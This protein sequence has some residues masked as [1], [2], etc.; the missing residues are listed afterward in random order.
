MWERI[1]Y[2]NNSNISIMQT[3]VNRLNKA[4]NSNIAYHIN[5]NQLHIL[6][7]G[8][9]ARLTSY[10]SRVVGESIV[11]FYKD[12]F[13][14]SRLTITGKYSH[15]LYK[16]ILLF[17]LKLDSSFVSARLDF[18][19]DI[20]V[21]SF[22]HFR[23]G[24]LKSKWANLCKLIVSNNSYLACGEVAVEFFKFLLDNIECTSV[25]QINMYDNVYLLKIDSE[26]KQFD[27]EEDMLLHLIECTPKKIDVM[28]SQS[29]SASVLGVM[30]QL[31]GKK[32]NLL[33]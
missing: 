27:T 2:F 6:L 29:I 13:I 4:K 10:I 9:I 17:E 24:V 11:Y 28:C 33:T 8:D 23:C 20:V 12:K 32:I 16:L 31:F 15:V 14:E 25:V 1:I 19:K 3:I 7:R 5:N 21:H 30:Y 22:F 18:D 26:V